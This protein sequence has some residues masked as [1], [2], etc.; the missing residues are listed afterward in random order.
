MPSDIISVGITILLRSAHVVSESWY[1]VV[2]GILLATSLSRMLSHRHWGRLS[3]LP[4]WLQI[5]TATTAGMISPLHTTSVV[6]FIVSLSSRCQ[7][8]GPSLSFLAASSMMNPQLFL[9]ALGLLGPE[10]A[11][12]QLSCV[13]TI[14]LALGFAVPL[15]ER[16][17]PLRKDSVQDMINSLGGQERGSYLRQSLKMLEYVGLYYLLG[18]I[19]GVSL[20]LFLPRALLLQPLQSF[21]WLSVPLAG[22]LG[23]PLYLCGGGAVPLARSLTEIGISRGAMLA[24]LVSGQATRSTALANVSCL[25]RNKALM[26]YVVA[27][28][29]GSVMLGYGFDLFAG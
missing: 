8:L 20:E 18:V 25:L 13:F 12:A 7:F 3:S 24:F 10:F 17:W 28:V 2:G 19:L 16:R 29:M 21:P 6:P 23:V 27:I 11:F 4:L 1:F 26:A 22:W 15:L 14:A 5:P 9:L